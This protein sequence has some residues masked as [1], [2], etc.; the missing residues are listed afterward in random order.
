MILKT[1]KKA[2]GKEGSGYSQPDEE[3]EKVNV[4]IIDRDFP[5]IRDVDAKLI[6]LAKV[7][8]AKVITNDFHLN[9]I[10]EL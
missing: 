4:K 6:K 1:L 8:E 9:K 10:A 5:E 7:L 2:T 3:R